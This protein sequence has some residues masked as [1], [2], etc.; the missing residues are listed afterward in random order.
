MSAWPVATGDDFGDPR[1]L[2][3]RAHMLSAMACQHRSPSLR[4]AVGSASALIW[5]SRSC[6]Y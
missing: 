4:D 1:A 6:K 3:A 2:K 5:P